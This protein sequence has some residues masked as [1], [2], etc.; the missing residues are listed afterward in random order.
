MTLNFGWRSFA[1]SDEQVEMSTAMPNALRG[2]RADMVKILF[3]LNALVAFHD[4]VFD[5]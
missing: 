5:S 2:V 3:M 1:L 4:L